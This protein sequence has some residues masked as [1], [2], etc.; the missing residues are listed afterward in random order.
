M[1]GTSNSSG[2]PSPPSE[3]ER[4]SSSVK[5]V[6]RTMC[7]VRVITMSVSVASVWLREKIR[8]ITGMLPRPGMPVRLWR[9]ESLMRPARMLVSP[10]RSRITLL[11]VRL[12]KVGRFWKSG[13]TDETSSFRARVTSPS[14]WTR[15]VMSM[16]TPT[17]L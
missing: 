16:L 15:G 2:V 4:R 12:L 17:F 6:R 13:P 11:T 7:G 1:A 8:P 14:W 3:K 10:S 9:S 5:T